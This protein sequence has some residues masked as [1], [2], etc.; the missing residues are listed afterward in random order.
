MKLSNIKTAPT[1]FTE[2]ELRDSGLP[3]AGNMGA[4]KNEVWALALGVGVLILLV[5]A[6]M[7]DTQL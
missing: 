3:P 4:A 1:G 6:A 5:V 2:R 7:I